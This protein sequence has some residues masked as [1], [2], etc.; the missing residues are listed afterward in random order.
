M[1]IF[2]RGFDHYIKKA[3]EALK[4]RDH[5]AATEYY[6][7]AASSGPDA[8][9]E[10]EQ[11]AWRAVM[12]NESDFGELDS[13]AHLLTLMKPSSCLGWM[14]SAKVTIELGRYDE[15]ESLIQRADG[16]TGTLPTEDGIDLTI[17]IYLLRIQH[18]KEV[19]DTILANYIADSSP[20]FD[21]LRKI[22]HYATTVLNRIEEADRK[23]PLRRDL[24]VWH[25]RI[26]E[27]WP[28][29][30]HRGAI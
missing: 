1:N 17:S 14:A 4:V 19:Q 21:N 22:Q 20:V 9:R 26:S 10:M 3:R 8:L 23:S 27:E 2:S 7:K 30:K 18:H 6:L 15:F 11:M 13:L 25:K 28:L 5:A 16:L 12:R 24:W 29:L